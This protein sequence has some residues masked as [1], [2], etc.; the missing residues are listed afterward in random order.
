[1]YCRRRLPELIGTHK[2]EAKK[3]ENLILNLKNS[4]KKRKSQPTKSKK[5]SEMGVKPRFWA[6]VNAKLIAR[7]TGVFWAE[8]KGKKTK[9]TIQNP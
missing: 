1:M 9:S 8:G 7:G 3:I 2:F 5:L 6:F 4:E